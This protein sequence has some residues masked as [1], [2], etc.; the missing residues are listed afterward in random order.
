MAAARGR[1]V[2]L[3]VG[4][5]LTGLWFSSAVPA[6][7]QGFLPDT[8]STGMEKESMLLPGTNMSLILSK[9]LN[10]G[11]TF[12]QIIERTTV[13]AARAIRH[14]E[15]GSLQEGSAAD[16]ALFEIQQ[17]KYG[18]LDSGYTRL[19]A[20]KRVAC[21]MTVRN[22]EIVWDSDGLAAVDWIKAGPYS[23]FK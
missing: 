15:L 11:L 16:L 9:F 2:L 7:R 6:I 19:N 18:F 17:G 14:S 23:N 21:V 13:N 4:A 8:I 10:M 5:G 12:D 3:D 22:G 20:N 1:G